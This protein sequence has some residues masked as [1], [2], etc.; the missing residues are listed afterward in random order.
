[1]W[2]FSLH[3]EKNATQNHG[4]PRRAGATIDAQQAS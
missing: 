4:N 1:M 2:R 3:K